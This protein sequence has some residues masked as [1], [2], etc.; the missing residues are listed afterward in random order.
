MLETG[1]G[2]ARHQGRLGRLCPAKVVPAS[3]PRVK[4][5]RGSS[6]WFS[7]AF[8]GFLMVSWAV[9]AH[10]FDLQAFADSAL[11]ATRGP[12]FFADPVVN[13]TIEAALIR[14]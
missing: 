4:K 9:A 11:I 8:F 7:L 6:F 5:S 10:N 2:S 1:A 13:A 12:L 3:S 14:V